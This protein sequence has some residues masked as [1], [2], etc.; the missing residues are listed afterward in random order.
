MVHANLPIA[1]RPSL[2]PDSCDKATW[3][4]SCSSTS[5]ITTW[6]LHVNIRAV[7]APIPDAAPETMATLSASLIE[8]DPE[9]ETVG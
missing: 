4:P 2:D 1:H 6:R 5:A 8:L 9:I 3:R 7:A